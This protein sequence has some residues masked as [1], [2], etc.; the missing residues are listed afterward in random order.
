MPNVSLKLSKRLVFLPFLG[1][2]AFFVIGAVAQQAGQGLEVTPPSQDVLVNPGQTTTVRAGIRNRSTQAKEV[3]VRLEDFTASGEEGQIEF[4]ANS[5]YSIK[6]WAKLSESSFT[7]DPGE[8]KEVVA[9]LNVPQG[10]AGGRYGSFVFS[11]SGKGGANAAALSQEIASLFLV[12]VSG[13]AE[14]K[15]SLLEFSVPNFSEFGPIT[16]TSKVKNSGNVYVKAYGLINVTDM[17][18]KKVKDVVV[19]ETNVFPGSNRVLKAELPNKWLFGQY[20]ANLFLTY[21][22]SANETLTSTATFYVFPIRI[23]AVLLVIA[24]VLI[25][26]RKRIRKASKAL[27]GK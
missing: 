22:S 6:K 26:G 12:R 18:G 2:L 17:F 25:F 7:L 24:L 19:Y 14:E 1:L 9:T 21:G 4:D 20:K 5:N 16:F 15:L 27:L 11:I 8:E 10:T 23:A 3:K 13:P